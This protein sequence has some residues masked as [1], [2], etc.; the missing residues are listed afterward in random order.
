VHGMASDSTHFC[1]TTVCGWVGG[2]DDGINTVNTVNTEHGHV[3]CGMWAFVTNGLSHF[4]AQ[5][6]LYLAPRLL[7]VRV[8]RTPSGY[9][10]Q[11]GGE[12]GS[13]G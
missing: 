6:S 11:S 12:W 7:C 5:S 4:S 8:Y 1:G 3:A 10:G 9:M 13:E 2:G